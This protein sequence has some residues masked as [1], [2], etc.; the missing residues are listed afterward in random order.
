MCGRITLTRPN[1]ESVASELNVS[2]EG[3]RGYPRLEPHYNIAPTSVHP[4]LT[5]DERGHRRIEPMTWG[6][7]PKAGKG[8]VINWRSE[9]FP[10]RAP[11]CAVITDGFYEWTGPK[12]ARQP[13][14]FHRPDFA[15]VM[16]A[17]LW[18]WQTNAD[19]TKIQVFVILTTRANALMAPIHHRMPVVIGESQLDQWMSPDSGNVDAIR[20]MLS[21]P[22]EKYLVADKASPLAN[23]VKNDGPE[24]LPA[25]QF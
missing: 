3:C 11:R 17:G 22:S 23:S 8:L 9:S 7:I 20:A 16:M 13:Y 12:T 21:P 15:L 6:S 5:L 4:I 1:L 18:K 25:L 24:L 19:G 10:P 2:P 14:W